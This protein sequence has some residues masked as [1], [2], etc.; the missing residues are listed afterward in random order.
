MAVRQSRPARTHTFLSN[1]LLETA[2]SCEAP[3]LVVHDSQVVSVICRSKLLRCNG[4]A[5]SVRDALSERTS[6]DFD[7]YESALDKL[8]ALTYLGTRSR[9]VRQPCYR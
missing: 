4:H 8:A 9:G 6:G 1:T 3:D 7:S 5:D 2:V